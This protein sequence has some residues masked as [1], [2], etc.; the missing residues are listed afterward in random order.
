MEKIAEIKQTP[1]LDSK[2]S[3]KTVQRTICIELKLFEPT[4]DDY[5]EFN[6]P[7]LL[8]KERQKHKKAQAAA[9]VAASIPAT[10]PE[11]SFAHPFNNDSDDDEDVQRLAAKMNEKYGNGSG[12]VEISDKAAGYDESD[13]FIDNTEAFDEMI[14]DDTPRGGFYINSG[15]LVFNK[16][17]KEK[18]GG[19]GGSVSS[20]KKRQS[21]DTEDEGKSTTKK[22]FKSEHKKKKNKQK[23]PAEDVGHSKEKGKT[24]AIK[25]V[26][27]LQR[28]NALKKSAVNRI[29]SDEED[30]EGSR[31][32]AETSEDS[33]VKI[34]ESPKPSTMPPG[35]PDTMHS[36]ISEFK[37]AIEKK[38]DDKFPDLRAR[39]DASSLPQDTKSKVH[40]YLTS[41][42][43]VKSPGPIESPKLDLPVLD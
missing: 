24:M 2:K 13:S 18:S 12:Y 28:D 38:D 20:G 43:P 33:D 29:V 40:A 15:P 36:L 27:R 22:K 37:I 23:E 7:E 32:S 21:L 10:I 9:N 25:D 34:V 5:P 14:M 16:N 19:S 17:V 39:V 35:I 31:T 6:V 30:S 41:L 42:M 8:Y 26:L 4:S 11:E 1:S 3:N